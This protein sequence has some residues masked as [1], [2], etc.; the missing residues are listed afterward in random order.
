M[1]T[2]R[3]HYFAFSVLFALLLVSCRQDMHDQAKYEPLEQSDFF[4]DQ[5]SSRAPVE[6]TVARGQLR[7]DEHFYTGKTN[8]QPVHTFPMEL[9]E[10]LLKRGQERYNIYCSPC[11]DQTGQGLGMVVQR[12]FKRPPSFHIQRLVNMPVGHYYDVIT[13]GFGVM[14][15]YAEQ[16]PPED[17]WAI[18][19]Y[20]RALQ[21][22]QNA[23]IADVPEQERTKLEASRGIP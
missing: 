16:V 4:G 6:G 23:T 13:N 15:S 18:T 3:L 10:Q 1:R 11:H 12:G 17:R 22:S 5:R 21:V 14:A 20:I 8:N 19:A 2:R 9:N 7:E